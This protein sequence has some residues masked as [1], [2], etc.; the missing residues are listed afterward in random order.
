MTSTATEEHDQTPEQML[1]ALK[2]EMKSLKAEEKSVKAQLVSLSEEL[3]LLVKAAA[4]IYPEILDDEFPKKAAA[5]QQ[6]QTSPYRPLRGAE[7][8]TRSP[9][10]ATGIPKYTRISY[11]SQES[12]HGK[13]ILDLKRYPRRFARHNS[14]ETAAQIQEQFENNINAASGI[15]A[16]KLRSSLPNSPTDDTVIDPN[17]AENSDEERRRKLK[18]K[19]IESRKVDVVHLGLF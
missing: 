11:R 13:P 10:G 15:D 7:D 8:T 19:M 16:R 1:L 18:K 12:A 2:A 17:Q 14:A 6:I 5:R 4:E 9:R 3:K